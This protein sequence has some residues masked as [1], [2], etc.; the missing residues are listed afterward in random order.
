MPQ[1]TDV[2]AVTDAVQGLQIEGPGEAQV[3]HVHDPRPH[4]LEER[5]RDDEPRAVVI[6][7]A[8]SEE[9]RARGAGGTARVIDNSLVPTPDTNSDLLFDADSYLS[10]PTVDGQATDGL[11]IAFAGKIKYEATDEAGRAQFEALTLGKAVEL[12]VSGV[13]TKKSGAWKVVSAETE[14]EREVVT[15]AVGVKVTDLRIL[16]PEQL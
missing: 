11:E 9:M 13:V 4:F 3:T 2:S 7:E 6:D 12:R 8:K 14:K 1:G 16:S 15:G 5:E 10:V